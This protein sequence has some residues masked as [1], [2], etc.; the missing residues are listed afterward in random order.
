VHP[1]CMCEWRPRLKTDEQIIA[2]ME[3]KLKDLEEGGGSG[4]AE[5]G[6]QQPS[7]L[8]GY[9]P[10]GEEDSGSVDM[11]K[12]FGKEFTQLYN[13]SMTYIDNKG[14][15]PANVKK[16]LDDYLAINGKTMDGFIA[17]V[18]DFVKTGEV[19]RHDMLDNFLENIDDF[20][21]DPR[22]KTQFETGTSQGYLG[23]DERN[24]WERRLIGKAE[25]YGEDPNKTDLSNYGIAN[26]HRPVYAEVTKFHPLEGNAKGYGD[27]KIAFVFS[28][29]AKNR[30][31]FTLDNSSNLGV[32]SFRNDAASVFSKPMVDARDNARNF[33]QAQ[34]YSSCYVEAQVW[35][36]IDLS[37]GDVKAVVISDEVFID[38]KNDTSFQRFI[39]VVENSGVTVIKSSAWGNQMNRKIVDK[40]EV[41]LYNNIKMGDKMRLLAKAGKNNFI[42]DAG[43]NWFHAPGHSDGFYLPKD[44][45]PKYPLAACLKWGFQP[46]DVGYLNALSKGGLKA[47][48]EYVKANPQ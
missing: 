28:D 40:T 7:E 14:N 34:R 26:V 12:R 3:A 19:V 18:N 35:G 2:D 30:A 13:E 11:E 25:N 6:D 29:N 45:K 43:D 9:E 39:K 5:G 41:K 24:H 46:V 15:I 44:K 27:R 33:Y 16:E 38:R 1:N 31:S 17:E 23:E 21:N 47:V 48:E 32:G 8:P 4:E 10:P 22:I 20:E 37:K 42:Y 36:G